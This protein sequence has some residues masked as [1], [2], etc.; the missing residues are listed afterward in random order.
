MKKIV[1]LLGALLLANGSAFAACDYEC[2]APYDMNSKF[3]TF[4]GS[5]SG[6]NFLS[7]KTTQVIVRK[8]I[9]KSITS[10][11]LKV[12]LDSYSS[13]DLKNGIFKSLS[14]TGNNVSV[15]D[16][17]LSYLDMKT[18]CDFNYIRQN[19]SDMFFVE[20]F[21]MS[22]DIRLTA[23]DIN[24]TMKNERYQRVIND[25][26]KL[27]KSY[28]AGIQISSTRVAIKSNK[29]YY[30][31]GVTIPFVRAEQKMVI[32]SDIVVRNKKIDFTNTQLVS[33]IFRLDLHKVDFILNY[34]N[35]LDFSVNI[36]DNKDAKVSVNN[37]SIKNNMI[38]TD[39][40]AVI[41]KD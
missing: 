41:P 30:I 13:K 32:T 14:I 15:K 21:P 37:V 2:V 20:D 6:F 4:L 3:R 11:D 1:L 10:D 26:N 17:Y 19:G 25:F 33:N 31:I 5:A 38:Y 12:K 29:F 24:K 35:P 8:A 40:V 22:F 34:L 28:G 23:S 7:E 27:A 36:L 16:I 9:S 39:G 18:L